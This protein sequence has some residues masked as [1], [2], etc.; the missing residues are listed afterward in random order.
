[1]RKNCLSVECSAL[2]LRPL[3]SGGAELH[4]QTPALLLPHTITTLSSSFLAV[5]AVY[6]FEKRTNFASSKLLQLFSLQTWYI[7]FV[8]R[9]VKIFLAPGRRVL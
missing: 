6:Y 8:D 4:P 3:A 7:V 1:M 2:D 5:N 9:G